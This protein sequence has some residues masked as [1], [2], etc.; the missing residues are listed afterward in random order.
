MVSCLIIKYAVIKHYEARAFDVKVKEVDAQLRTMSGHVLQHG[1]F[2]ES[3]GG[4]MA[5]PCCEKS[6]AKGKTPDK[7]KP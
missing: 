3:G 2:P 5:S 6:A 4:D 1:F 7:C